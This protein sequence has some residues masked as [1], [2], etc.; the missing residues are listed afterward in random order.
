MKSDVAALG[1]YCAGKVISSSAGTWGHSAGQI[2]KHPKSGKLIGK[3]PAAQT[4]QA[5][6]NLKSLAKKN[7]FK[8][9]RETVKATVFL[10]SMS[11]FAEC[12]AV[13]AKYFDSDCLPARSCVAVKEL[14]MGALFEIE[15]IFFKA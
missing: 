7:G 8:L 3:S 5:M 14:P 11:H 2:A 4:K 12:N 15:A 6:Q 10:T 9:N 13:Y 1:P